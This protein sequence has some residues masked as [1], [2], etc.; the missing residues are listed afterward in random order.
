MGTPQGRNKP[1]RRGQGKQ[2]EREATWDL[3]PLLGVTVV[4]GNNLQQHLRPGQAAL[5]LRV[6]QKRYIWGILNPKAFGALLQEKGDKI[7]S[8]CRGLRCTGASQHQLA[9]GHGGKLA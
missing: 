1:G 3:T 8:T 5:G 2:E 6:P 7:C 9:S 4:A